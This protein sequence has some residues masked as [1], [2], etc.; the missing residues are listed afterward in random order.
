MMQALFSLRNVSCSYGGDSPVIDVPALDIPV[1]GIIAI[2]GESGA[3]KSTLLNILGALHPVDKTSNRQAAF[4]P[5]ENTYIDLTQAEPGDYC[6]FIFQN[7]YLFESASIGL[8]LDLMEISKSTDEDIVQTLEK[9]GIEVD[10]TRISGRVRN[11]SGG[12]KR[13]LA[14]IAALLRDR[15]T[16]LADELTSDL[17]P[18]WAYK[19]LQILKDWQHEKPTRTILWVTHNYEQALEFADKV[20]IVTPD[21]RLHPYHQDD[22]GVSHPKPW[23]KGD[24]ATVKKMISESYTPPEDMKIPA[25]ISKSHE[26]SNSKSGFGINGKDIHSAGRLALMTSFEQS[27]DGS[28]IKGALSS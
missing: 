21:G 28:G 22:T 13:R 6:S 8:N 15:D 5:N 16:I 12:Q 20:L 26:T 23:P 11:L 19:S 25:V 27:S 17:D 2:L 4:S 9:F 3:G 10:K 24:I 1:G 14:L 7:S 18:I